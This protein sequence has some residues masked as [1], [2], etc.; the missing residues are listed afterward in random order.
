VV[1]LQPVEVEIKEL[2]VTRLVENL[3][4]FRCRVSSGTYVRSLANDLGLRLGIGAHLATLRRTVSAEFT[5]EQAHVLE[6]IAEAMTQAQI[7]AFL[8]HPRRLLPDI[9]SITANAEAIGKIRHGRPVN[10][11]EMSGSKWVKVFAGQAELICLA[12]RVAGT[13]FHPKVVLT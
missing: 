2:E 3:V 12:R 4:Y 8:V 1:G 6:E 9:P 10:L 7:D 5:L 13:L 11:P